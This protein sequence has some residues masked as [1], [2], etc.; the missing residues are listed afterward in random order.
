MWRVLLI[1]TVIACL[2]I[3][4]SKNSTSSGS[5]SLPVAPS[6]VL[7]SNAANPSISPDG[8]RLIYTRAGAAFYRVLATGTEYPL[9]A[10]PAGKVSWYRDSRNAVFATSG[11]LGAATT[12]IFKFSESTGSASRLYASGRDPVVATSSFSVNEI[13]L[14]EE[15]NPAGVLGLCRLLLP[16]LVVQ[17][18]STTGNHVIPS[19]YSAS[20]AYLGGANGN[21]P[22]LARPN[23]NDAAMFERDAYSIAFVDSNTVLFDGI[24]PSNVSPRLFDIYQYKLNTRELTILFP[25]ASG[26]KVAANGDIAFRSVSTTGSQLILYHLGAVSLV[27][28]NTGDYDITDQGKVVFEFDN[29][30]YITD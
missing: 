21:V 2:T 17:T 27:L 19:P 18:M 16:Q 20:Y 23:L 6:H 24:Q 29:A 3:S 26:P 10:M 1:L 30:I 5:N 15:T 9:N 11:L 25:N 4:C 12:G 14:F 8:T 28:S 22:M 7:L 13:I